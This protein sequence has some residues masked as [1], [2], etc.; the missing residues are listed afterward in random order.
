MNK[1][2]HQQRVAKEQAMAEKSKR[3][4]AFFE[5]MEMRRKESLENEERKRAQR[6][7]EAEHNRKLLE[8]QRDV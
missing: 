4:V 3:D 8:E 6:K 1:E 2:R 7:Q 5:E